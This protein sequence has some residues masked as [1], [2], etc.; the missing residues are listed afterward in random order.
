MGG[1]ILGWIGLFVIVTSIASPV[2]N[3]CWPPVDQ[4]SKPGEAGEK[5]DENASSPSANAAAEEASNA[6]STEL[7]RTFGGGS[8]APAG[9]ARELS[10]VSSEYVFVNDDA[11]ANGLNEEA[12]QGTAEGDASQRATCGS[13]AVRKM[14]VGPRKAADKKA[15]ENGRLTRF[16]E[17]LLQIGPMFFV[18]CFF[19]VL[20][21]CTYYWGTPLAIQIACAWHIFLA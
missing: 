8:G 20:R 6:G 18:V 7:Q 3:Y 14:A 2:W 15:L 17:L 4:R 19:Y 16:D 9:P 13:C 10:V 5:G 21:C 1:V 12:E 11:I